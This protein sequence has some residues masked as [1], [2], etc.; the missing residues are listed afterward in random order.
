LG[1][2]IGI[3]AAIVP[4][5][6]PEREP[7]VTGALKIPEASESWAENTFPVLNVPVE[8]NGTLTAE[9]AQNGLPVIDPVLIVFGL[10]LVDSNAPR[11]GVMPLYGSPTLVPPSIKSDPGVSCISERTGK[12]PSGNL[13]PVTP[14]VE[15][16]IKSKELTIKRLFADP[17]KRKEL[18]CS[19]LTLGNSG[20]LPSS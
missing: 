7:I 14:L 12:L 13:G 16:L 6:I 2:P 5:V 1:V 10:L 19:V 17:L 18:F 20:T 15:V 9:P 11:S 3:V 4:E 8:V